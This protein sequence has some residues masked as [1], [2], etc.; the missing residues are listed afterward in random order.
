M[1][2][3]LDTY[4][5]KVQ[6]NSVAIIGCE[7]GTA[8]QIHSWL[9]KTGKYQIACFINP[10]DQPI[11]IDSSKIYRDATQFAYPTKTGF[12]DNETEDDA[13]KLKWQFAIVG[14]RF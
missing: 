10:T 1:A 11:N 3:K 9:G 8:G 4:N 14:Q 5:V 2:N 12:K 6:D 7:E 13:S